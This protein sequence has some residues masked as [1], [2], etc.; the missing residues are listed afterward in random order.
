MKT[1][2]DKIEF[3]RKACI[4]ANGEIAELKFGC[5]VKGSRHDIIGQVYVNTG[6]RIEVM[7]GCDMDA[8]EIDSTH[9]EIIGRPIRLA[10][11]LWAIN[12]PIKY[13]TK[14]PTVKIELCKLLSSWNLLKDNLEDQSEET[15]TFISNLIKNND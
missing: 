1:Y 15:V 7:F 2:Q 5:K 11:V 14:T 4:E 13:H 8:Y 12:M 6:D 9:F 10:D 3:I